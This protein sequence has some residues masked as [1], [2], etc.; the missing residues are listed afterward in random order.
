MQEGSQQENR[1]A[2]K[3][4]TAEKFLAALILIIAALPLYQCSLKTPERLLVRQQL[5]LP[6]DIVFEKIH[7]FGKNRLVAPPPVDAT[8]RF[9]DLQFSEYVAKLGDPAIW[10][11]VPFAYYKQD[12]WGNSTATF[13]GEAAEGTYGWSDIPASPNAA[14]RKRICFVWYQPVSSALHR[15]APCS[16]KPAEYAKIVTVEGI[17][18]L[19]GKALDVTFR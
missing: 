3:Y 9:T 13:E 5:H 8:V 15:A 4:S 2:R 16:Q 7:V 11:A 6:D 18:D 12:I 1:P 14:A 17:L 19:E 10:K